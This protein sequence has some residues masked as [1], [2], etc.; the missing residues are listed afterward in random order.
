MPVQCA[1]RA[2]AFSSEARTLAG[3]RSRLPIARMRTFFSI[4]SGS[5]FS[6]NSPGR[7]IR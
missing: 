2:I 1:V 6:K 5:S 4:A 7:R 3:S